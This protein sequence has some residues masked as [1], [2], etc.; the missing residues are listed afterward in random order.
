MVQD[1]IKKL[2]DIGFVWEGW[3]VES[4]SKGFEET[5]RYKEQRGNA[6]APRD[7]TTPDGFNLGTWQNTQRKKFRTGKL[8]QD[9]IKKLEGIGFVWERLLKNVNINIVGD[10]NN[11]L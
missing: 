8:E 11:V 2:E 4:F 9:R 7:Y 1:R 3:R 10:I 5:L 6:N